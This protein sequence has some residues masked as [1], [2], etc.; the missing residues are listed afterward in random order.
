MKQ[1]SQTAHTTLWLC[2]LGGLLH[3]Y[4]A[5][6]KSSGGG[7]G[8]SATLFLAGLFLW[9]CVPYAVWTAVAVVRRQAAPAVGGA[10]GTLAFDAYMHYS[11]FVAPSGSTAALGLLFAPLW[12]LILFGP[13]GALF[14]WLL[15]HL[16]TPR[17]HSNHG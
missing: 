4:T 11:V 8:A 17:R 2:A 16:V 14:S 15:L 10:I 7:P 5:V 13:L 9:S 3:A 6:F 12:N 1:A